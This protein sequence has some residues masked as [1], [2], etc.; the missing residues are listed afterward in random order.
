MVRA[1]IR[2]LNL[3]CDCVVVPISSNLKPVFLGT[4]CKRLG[5][6]GEGEGGGGGYIHIR[7]GKRVSSQRRGGGEEGG[8]EV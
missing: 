7:E 1:R 6:G 4:E 5:G 3:G 8:G 2:A